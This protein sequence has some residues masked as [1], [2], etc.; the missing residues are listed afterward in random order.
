[1]SETRPLPSQL[2]R[3][4]AA[5]LILGTL[6]LFGLSLSFGLNGA[7]L[8]VAFL[9]LVFGPGLL[10]RRPFARRALLVFTRIGF[11][12]VVFAVVLA[13]RAPGPYWWAMYLVSVAV[14]WLLWV[15]RRV[16]MRPDVQRVFDPYGRV[17]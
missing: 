16:L 15:Q 12:Y 6:A 13:L 2:A 7:E 14:L 3:L 10:F 4:A 1:M 17:E 5:W 8:N 11:V 9:G